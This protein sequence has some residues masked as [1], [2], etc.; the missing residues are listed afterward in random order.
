MISTNLLETSDVK[1]VITQ[2]GAF[3]VIEY[4]RD[5]SVD[6]EMAQASFFASQMEIRKRQLIAEIEDIGI[7][8]QKGRMQLML[9][10]IEAT[11]DI[12]SIGGLVKSF[13]GSKVVE[14]T[15]IKP[16]YTGEG[17][18]VL[19]PTFRHILIEDLDDWKGG[20]IIEDGMF[21]ACYDTATIHVVSRKTVSSVVFG[22]EGLFNTCITGDGFV[23]LESPIPRSELIEINIEDDSIKIDG[24][25]AIAWSS[26]LEF[27]VERTT[28]TLIGSVAAGEG[29]V[30]VYRGTGKVLVAPVQ[31]NKEIPN[32]NKKQ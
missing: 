31:N 8:A 22:G 3:T 7:V 9:G 20:L 25:M 28:P 18:L 26:D 27:T 30:N 1:K 6:P 15:A 13:L 12:K 2:K 11:T 19:E 16:L 29:F 32:P 5:L 21:L 23:A 4:E 14:E 10:D 24:N 17:T